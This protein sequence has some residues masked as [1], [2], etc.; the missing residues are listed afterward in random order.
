M[1]IRAREE[2]LDVLAQCE[3]H[4]HVRRIPEPRVDEMRDEL[5]L[6]LREA[7]RNGKPVGTVVGD[8]V[9]AFAESWA[10][11]NRPHWP[12]RQ[13]I[14]ESGYTVAVMVAV[15]AA[16]LHLVGWDFVVQ[17]GWVEAVLL[18]LTALSFIITAAH[19]RGIG[20]PGREMGWP[21]VIAASLGS[22]GIA[23]GLSL[24]ATGERNGMLLEWPWYATVATVV[25]ALVLGR[26]R[27]KSGGSA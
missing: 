19:I 25:A 1:R 2:I 20:R 11:E 4:W 13:R 10:G 12:M 5:H 18:L 9:P 27:E 17:V 8:D 22:V 15:F 3:F 26:F 23:W 21:V 16:L 6:H 7:A 24:L 14:A